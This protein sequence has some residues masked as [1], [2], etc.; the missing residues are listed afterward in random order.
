[1]LPQNMLGRIQDTSVSFAMLSS[2]PINK[3]IAFHTPYA[4][5]RHAKKSDT[6]ETS[7][8]S[9]HALEI[10]LFPH[11]RCQET[12]QTWRSLLLYV[13][14]PTL[15]DSLS[16]SQDCKRYKVYDPL[17]KSAQLS[18]YPSQC[19]V[20]QPTQPMATTNPRQLETRFSEMQHRY[21]A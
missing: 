10:H 9:L 12:D 18:L 4:I 17:F 7:L 14:L 5:R 6:F 19:A 8:I 20:D 1:M 2:R 16:I 13:Y 15:Q 21:L 3:N 11:G